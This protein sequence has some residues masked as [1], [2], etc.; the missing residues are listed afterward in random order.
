M[1]INSAP[2]REKARHDYAKA[3]RELEAAREAVERFETQDRPAYSRWY[4]RQFGALLTELRELQQKIH[5]QGELIDEVESESFIS[6]C[7]LARAYERVMWRRAHPE[8]AAA[9][10]ARA[11][12]REKESDGPFGS[13][14]EAFFSEFAEE[15]ERMFTGGGQP[16]EPPPF[17]SAPP[18]ARKAP[19]RLKELYRALARQLHPDVQEQMTPQKREWWHQVQEAYEQGD[20]E[21]LQVILTLCE[22]EEQGSTASTS[23]SLLMRIT[24]ELKSSLRALKGQLRRFRQDPAW[25]FSSAGGR[26]EMDARVQRALQH[27]LTQA[28]RVLAAI[29]GQLKAWAEQSRMSPRRPRRRG[30]LQPEFPF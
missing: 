21:R 22:I 27:E 23:V 6:E 1:Q 18:G 25:N 4:N 29:E 26:P 5:S 20:V 12:A 3:L 11:E 2:I 10:A 14:F 8:E 15:F 28:R 24:R 19:A 7:S 9:E 17:S 30:R 13:D 16:G